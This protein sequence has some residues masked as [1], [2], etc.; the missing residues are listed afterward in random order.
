MK[1]PVLPCG[2]LVVISGILAGGTLGF[3]NVMY[4]FLHLLLALAR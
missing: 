3:R 1:V 4:C 2:L